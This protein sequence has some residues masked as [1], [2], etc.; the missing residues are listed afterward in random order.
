MA[1]KY[2]EAHHQTNKNKS[3]HSSRHEAQKQN[4]NT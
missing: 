4:K 2:T 1:T 3:T